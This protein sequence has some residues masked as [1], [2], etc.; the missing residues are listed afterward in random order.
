MRGEKKEMPMLKLIM[1]C[2]KRFVIDRDEELCH[3]LCSGGIFFDNN[4]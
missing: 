3:S 1:L 4:H 2:H